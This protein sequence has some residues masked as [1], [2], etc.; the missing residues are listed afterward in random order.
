MLAGLIVAALAAAG[1]RSVPPVASFAANPNSGTPSL[2][3]DVDG[4]ASSD[5]DGTIV[6]YDWDFGDTT[7]GSGV[8]AT[9]VYA[10]TGTYRITLTVTDNAGDTASTTVD[11]DCISATN[12]PP[13]HTIGAFPSTGT[14]PLL[15]QVESLVHDD[16][17]THTET[18]DAGD[19]SPPVTFTNVLNHA[20][21][22]ITVT[23]ATPGS[24]IVTHRAID[25]EGIWREKTVVVTVT[26]PPVAGYELG[27]RRCG[28]TGAEAILLIGLIVLLKRMAR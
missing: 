22:L 12:L 25:P 14:A 24:Y 15:L 18:W 7:T 2:S 1:A 20:G 3:V 8:T 13:L 21:T 6:S 11:V 23:Y 17:G 19:G 9:H 28:H 27:R 4:S 16:A 5:P 10:A 26:A